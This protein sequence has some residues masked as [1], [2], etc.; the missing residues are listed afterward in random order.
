MAMNAGSSMP[1]HCFKFVARSLPC[2]TV[3]WPCAGGVT[4]RTAG[5]GPAVQLFRIVAKIPA[6]MFVSGLPLT[7]RSTVGV[8]ANASAGNASK[9][10]IDARVGHF[11]GSTPRRLVTVTL[12]FCLL[13]GR[14]SRILCL[15]R[16]PCIVCDFDAQEKQRHQYC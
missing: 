11:I 14:R 7:C 10:Q 1:R 5:R 2:L 3:T 13:P 15:E 9:Q 12:V 16:I 8:C 4:S 6:L